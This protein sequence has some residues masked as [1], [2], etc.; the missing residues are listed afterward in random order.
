M[1]IQSSYTNDN[2]TLYV[3]PTP[4][5]NLSDITNRGLEILNDVDF[6]FCEDKRVS[7]KLLNH[8]DIKSK[9]DVYHEFNSEY[10]INKILGFL[11]EGFDVAIITDA[12]L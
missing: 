11:N 8:Y 5:G 4:I 12:G 7:A 1:K 2:K 9:L 10:A 6:I 3:V